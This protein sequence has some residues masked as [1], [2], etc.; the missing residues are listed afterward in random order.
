MADLLLA[1]T[2]SR[3]LPLATSPEDM[4]DQLQIKLSYSMSLRLGT[5]C[6]ANINA[7]PIG[8]LG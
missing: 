8:T 3:L 7:G 2:R 1:G 5:I 4:K 6:R